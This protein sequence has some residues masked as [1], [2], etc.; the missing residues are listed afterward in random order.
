MNTPLEIR[1]FDTAVAGPLAGLALSILFV[2]IGSLYHLIL[3]QHQRYRPSRSGRARS[4]VL[5]VAIGAPSALSAPPDVS[6]ALHLSLWRA[7]RVW[8]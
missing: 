5:L 8:P 6:V 3:Q 1:L 4:G 2:L 7:W